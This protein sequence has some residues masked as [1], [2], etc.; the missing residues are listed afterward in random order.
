MFSLSEMLDEEETFATC[1]THGGNHEDLL[2]PQANSLDTVLD[3]ILFLS[4]VGKSVYDLVKAGV[5]NSSRQARYYYNAAAFLG[6]CY[7]RGDYFYPTELRDALSAAAEAR[8]HSLFAAMVLE[9]SRIN[10][11][12]VGVF[13]YVDRESR[14]KWIEEQ[15]APHIVAHATLRRRASC[16]HAWFA[17]IQQNLQSL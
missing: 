10:S 2:Y 14:I 8:R 3:V 17:W 5:V 1:R 11:L 16:L 9:N 13:R 15:I 4:V 6:F 7:R 12:Y